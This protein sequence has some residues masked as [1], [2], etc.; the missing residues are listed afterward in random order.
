MLQVVVVRLTSQKL[1]YLPKH[2]R[3]LSVLARQLQNRTAQET[4]WAFIKHRWPTLRKRL[5][6]MLAA[7]L[8]AATSALDPSLA[9]DVLSFFKANPVPTAKRTLQQVQERFRYAAAF[10]RRAHKTLAGC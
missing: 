2:T 3:L 4:T 7:R 8:I 9:P 5:T 10:K 6:P 1:Q